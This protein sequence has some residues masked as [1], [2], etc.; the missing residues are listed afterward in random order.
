MLFVESAHHESLFPR[1]SVIVHHGGAGTCAAA[2][3]AGV[4]SIV[5]P[6]FM[7]QPTNGKIIADAGVGL[8]TDHFRTVTADQLG[9]AL[10]K[11]ASDSNMRAKCQDLGKRLQE[12]QGTEAALAEINRFIEEEVETGQ[13]RQRFERRCQRRIGPPQSEEKTKQDVERAFMDEV[14]RQERTERLQ[15]CIVL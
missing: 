15:Q 2:L 8:V 12:H 3:R 13:W 9:P 7:D 10:H 14:Y 11:C 1:C 4:P 6:F 5:T